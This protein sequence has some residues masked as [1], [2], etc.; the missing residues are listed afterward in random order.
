[1]WVSTKKY[2]RKSLKFRRLF[3]CYHI[4]GRYS[5]FIK[6]YT[7]DNENL[8]HLIIDHLQSI[9]EVTNTGT[10]ISLDDG[11]IRQ[12]PVDLAF[13]FYFIEGITPTKGFSFCL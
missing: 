8:K 12:V 5:L 9:P 3:E 7:K 11:F 6:V 1:M 2:L 10:F 13:P 4:S